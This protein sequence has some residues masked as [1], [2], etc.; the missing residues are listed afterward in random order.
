MSWNWKKGIYAAHGWLGLNFGLVLWIICLSGTVA[1]VS[2]EIDWLLNPALRVV[3]QSSRASYGRMYQAV[4]Q[5]Y[6]DAEVTIAWAPVGPRFACEFWL[7]E[8]GGGTQRV[9]VDPYTAQVQGVGSWFNTQRFFRDFHRRFFWFAWWGIWLVAAYGCVLLTSSLSGLLFY[10]RWWAKLFYLRW[11]KGGRLFWS[12]LHRLCGVWTM[13]FAVLIAA[14]GVWYFVEIPLRWSIDQPPPPQ[15]P[16]ASVDARQ[17]GTATLPVDE[18]V[19]I[20]RQTIPQLEVGAIFFPTRPDRPVRIDGQATA[21]LV[22]DRANSVLIDPISGAVLSSQ[23]A[24]QLGA[25]RRWE[26]T[27]DPLHFGNF[28]GLTSKVIWFA[29]GLA[30]CV[31]MP[32]GAYLW[33]RRARQTAASTAQRLRNVASGLNDREHATLIAATTRRRTGLGMATTT[34]ILLMACY[35]TWNALADQAIKA[36]SQR[37]AVA[38]LGGAG[39]VTVYGAFLTVVLIATAFWYRHIFVAVTRRRDD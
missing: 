6:P 2:H 31:L 23:R 9:Y 36:D 37:T 1:V 7:Q 20:A 34:L 21:W 16:E 39:S 33:V 14:T 8:T 19:R 25:L 32:T 17:R 24:E 29:F 4:R 38:L 22:R 5:Q 28:A 3:P 13:L 11:G 35:A 27:A 12:D 15:L 18:W 10:R 30:L 26:D